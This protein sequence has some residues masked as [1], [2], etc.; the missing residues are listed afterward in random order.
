MT[1]IDTLLLTGCGGDIAISIARFVRADGLAQRVIGAD[2]RADHPGHPYFDAVHVL[3]AAQAPDYGTA[4]R[5]LI[6]REGPDLV[7]PLSEAELSR[8]LADNAVGGG[9]GLF[10]AA[11]ARALRTGLDKLET[12]RMLSRAGIP[13][14]DTGIVGDVDPPFDRFIIKPR[15]GQGSKNIVVAEPWSRE[16]LLATR[17]GDLW[18]DV[19]PDAE[20]EYTCGVIRFP[21]MGV[22]TI[23]LRRKLGGGLTVSATVVEN[24]AIDEMLGALAEALALEGAINVQLRMRDGKPFVFE[25]NARFSSTVGFRHRIGFRDFV[26]SME[27]ALGRTPS[28]YEPAIAGTRL[29]RVSEEVILPPLPG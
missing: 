19:L 28:P 5:A 17:K 10:L 29:F 6:A 22:R 7:V 12:F 13:T 23:A 2:V 4:L 15:H 9:S 25:I 11:S 27:H 20:E 16:Q 21:G 18:Q 1:L 8:L 24:G 26:W 14:P 3:P